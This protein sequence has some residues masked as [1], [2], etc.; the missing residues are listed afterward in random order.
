MSFLLHL[1]ALPFISPLVCLWMKTM[2]LNISGIKLSAVDININVIMKQ[3]Q[4]L[5]I[6]SYN[7]WW[8]KIVIK[9]DRTL[10]IYSDN[11]VH[12]WKMFYVSNASYTGGIKLLSSTES[13]H[14]NMIWGK[15]SKPPQQSPNKRFNEQNNDYA[16]TLQIIIKN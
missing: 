8:T 9:D 2:S 12:P 13:Q 3:A 4:W 7:F 6:I 11:T 16:R 14:G 5:A 10:T 15:L 1:L